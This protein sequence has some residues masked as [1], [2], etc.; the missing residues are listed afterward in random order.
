[1]KTQLEKHKPNP[2]KNIH[3]TTSLTPLSKVAPGVYIF[4]FCLA[5]TTDSLH[6]DRTQAGS[7]RGVC[8]S[9]L[10][11][12]SS[13]ST[14]FR[15]LLRPNCVVEGFIV[16]NKNGDW[17]QLSLCSCPCIYGANLRSYFVIRGDEKYISLKLVCRTETAFIKTWSTY[18]LYD[19][20]LNTPSF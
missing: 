4:T 2:L 13:L 17:N 16:T 1:M 18:A 10:L 8:G 15:G 12:L 3:I 14:P 7:E 20:V 6:L 19:G 9:V 11:A 5:H